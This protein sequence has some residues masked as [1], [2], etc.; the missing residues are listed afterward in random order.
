[1][2]TVTIAY[3]PPFSFPG[4][5]AFGRNLKAFP[6][7]GEFVTYSDAPGNWP[8]AIPLNGN[9]EQFRGAKFSDGKPNPF[10]VHN[11]VWLTGLRI[12]RDRGATHV[13]YVEADC[14]MGKEGWDEIIFEEYFNLGKPAIV[15][16]TLSVYNPCNSTPR[17]CQKW[18]DL[19]GKNHRH[20]IPTATYGWFGANQPGPSCCFPN[21]ALAVYDMAWMQAFWNL[22]DTAGAA[23]NNTAFDMAIGQ[24]LWEMFGDDAYE[25]VGSL[26]SVFSG[27]GN[28]LTTEE[29]RLQMVRDGKIVGCHQVKGDEGI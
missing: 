1:M 28:V 27:Y 7:T 18:R 23:V 16:G 22:D 19:V 8:A 10:A 29:Q 17:G 15:A 14:R 9:P 11:V 20:G 13:L 26:D 2:K 4:A 24:K 21:G 5:E 6:P 3:C 12:A 25:V